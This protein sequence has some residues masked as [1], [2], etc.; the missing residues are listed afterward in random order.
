[1]FGLGEAAAAHVLV[2]TGHGRGRVVLHVAVSYRF[3][4]RK[5]RGAADELSGSSFAL[6]TVA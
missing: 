3:D 4:G 2:E 1:V 5:K 6:A